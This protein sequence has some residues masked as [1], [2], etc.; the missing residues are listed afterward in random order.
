MQP[1]AGQFQATHSPACRSGT[2]TDGLASVKPLRLPQRGDLVPAVVLP[3]ELE[4]A[5]ARAVMEH[6]APR[7][8]VAV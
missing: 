8:V 5:V 4:E 1:V 7:S 6:L 2:P 3:D